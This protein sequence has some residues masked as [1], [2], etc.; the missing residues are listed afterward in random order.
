MSEL[1]LDLCAIS[2]SGEWLAAFVG[3]IDGILNRRVEPLF[4]RF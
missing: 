2:V 4:L 3:V 1:A